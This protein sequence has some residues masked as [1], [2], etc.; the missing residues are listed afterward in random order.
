[1]I[2]WWGGVVHSSKYEAGGDA[3]PDHL[4]VLLPVNR[5]RQEWSAGLHRRSDRAR[6]CGVN[7][8]GYS[9][10][11]NRIQNYSSYARRNLMAPEGWPD[12]GK[13]ERGTVFLMITEQV[14]RF[15]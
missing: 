9:R 11:A 5:H 8:W 14:R 4:P 7:W 13:S 6:H 3:L 2:I 15:R 12:Y 10:R 1:M